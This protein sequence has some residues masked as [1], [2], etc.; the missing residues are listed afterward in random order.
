VAGGK[1][2]VSTG[3][4]LQELDAKSGDAGWSY[5]PPGYGTFASTPAAAGGLVFIGCTN[6]SLY[7]LR[8]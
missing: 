1:V 6:D 8:V 5:S 2:Y 4:A 7:A 3:I